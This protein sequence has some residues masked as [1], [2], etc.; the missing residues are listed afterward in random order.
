MALA[1][2]L[3]LAPE[4]EA[5]GGGAEGGLQVGL[6]GVGEEGDLA[7]VSGPKDRRFGGIRR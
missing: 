3:A 7:R 5:G 2:A 6:A 1:L 4:G